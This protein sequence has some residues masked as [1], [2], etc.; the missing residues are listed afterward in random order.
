MRKKIYNPDTTETVNKIVGGNPS[1]IANFV[2]PS[3]QIYKTIFE[4]QIARFWNPATINI[5]ED[6]KA[7]KDLSDAEY[8]AYELTFGKLIFNDSIVT[9]RIMDN[10]NPFITDPIL[11]HVSLFKQVKRLYTLIVMRL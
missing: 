5:T 10:I 2:K 4:G 3:R 9:N 8:R 7:V 1:G 11:M 6:K